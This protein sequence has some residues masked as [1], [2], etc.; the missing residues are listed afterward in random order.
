MKRTTRIATIA[1]VATMTLAASLASPVAGSIPQVAAAPQ[2]FEMNE[3]FP[4]A[5]GNA[6]QWVDA[7]QADSFKGL[8]VTDTM[9]V[10]G[11][12]IWVAETEECVQGESQTS[13]VMY[14]VDHEDGLFAT[15]YLG[16]LMDW[17]HD[18]DYTGMLQRWTQRN[19]TMGTHSFKSGGTA[20]A[21]TVNIEDGDPAIRIHDASGKTTYQQYAYGI[22]PVVRSGHFELQRATVGGV[23]Y[24][25]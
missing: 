14:F 5:V 4:M 13:G 16:T 24:V 19:V 9:D 18:T 10:E 12:V 17:S 7:D 22:G 1:A 2:A 3:F 23:E 8:R 20:Q 21:Y 15:R 11:Y 25:L 6:W